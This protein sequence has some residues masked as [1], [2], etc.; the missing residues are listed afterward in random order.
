M[1]DRAGTTLIELVVALLLLELVGAA[2]LAAAFTADR[3][4]RRV[5]TGAATDLARW[6]AYR[7]AEVTGACR[8]AAAPDTIVLRFSA[9]AGRDSL[10]TRVRCGP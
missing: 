3:L 6:E 10:T 7:A 8:G 5:A 4:G 9:T 1:A 2:A